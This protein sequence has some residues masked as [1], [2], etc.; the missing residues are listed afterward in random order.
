MRRYV[1][2]ASVI[3]GRR[4]NVYHA[5]D[6]VYETNFPDGHAEK[7]VSI[8]SLRRDG[9]EDGVPIWGPDDLELI[10]VRIPKQEPETTQSEN[11]KLPIDEISVLQLKDELRMR[12]IP[13]G[14]NSTKRELYNLWIGIQE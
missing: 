7:L 8:G 3:C 2:L 14:R 10:P 4:N 12:R 5:G 6:I 1:V 9:E 11:G 13:F